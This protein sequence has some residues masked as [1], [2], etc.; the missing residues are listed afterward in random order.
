L[1][2]VT[3]G[4][5]TGRYGGFPDKIFIFTLNSI[6]SYRRSSTMG[7]TSFYDTRR[8]NPAIE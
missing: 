7:F 1:D 8:N 2:F 4:F 6:S 3:G 5:D